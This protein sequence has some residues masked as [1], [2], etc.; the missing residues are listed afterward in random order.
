[1]TEHQKFLK[2]YNCFTYQGKN[3]INDHQE[4]E[5]LYIKLYL[6][7]LK[8]KLFDKPTE[9][10]VWLALKSFGVM[11]EE[12]YPTVKDIAKL[13]MVTDRTVQSTFKILEKKGIIVALPEFD[14]EKNGLQINNTY[15]L[16]PYD[17]KEKRFVTEKLEY[18]RKKKD[19]LIKL[20]NK[21]K[22]LGKGGTFP[23]SQQK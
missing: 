4:Q 6:D 5:P 1:M 20:L 11:K 9:L 13:A 15:H 3:S 2:Q 14:M 18:Y 16:A 22:E 19:M 23:N 10:S 21:E 7:M 8:E 17:K 12:V